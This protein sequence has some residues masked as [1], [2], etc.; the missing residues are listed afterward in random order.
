MTVVAKFRSLSSRRSYDRTTTVELQP[1][2]RD[3]RDAENNAF[4]EYSPNGKCELVLNPDSPNPFVDNDGNPGDFFR[5]F[6]EPD[7]NGALKLSHLEEN[8]YGTKVVLTLP[9][10]PQGTKVPCEPDDVASPVSVRSGFF[11]VQLSAKAAGAKEMLK[12]HG[13]RWTIRFEWAEDSDL[14]R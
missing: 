9:W 1:V 2:K 7:E 11:E 5:V 3:A 12:P 14:R 4:W 10:S 8:D 6:L 13:S